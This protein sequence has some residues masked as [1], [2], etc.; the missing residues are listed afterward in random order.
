[1]SMQKILTFGEILIR[2]Q[3]LHDSFFEPGENLLKIYPGGSEA[4]VAVSLAQ[5]G[6]QVEY[7][8]AF[9]ENKLSSEILNV[10]KSYQ[11]DTSKCIYFGDRIGTYLLLSA[12]GLTNGEVIYDRK[13][14]SFSQLRS[15]HIDIDRLFDGVD[16]F[17]WSA[18]SP[19]LNQ[20]TADMMEVL[21]Q[22]AKARNIC[23]SVDLNDRSKLWQYGK[24][25][26]DVMPK[27][28]AYCQ[29]IMGNIW[30][31]N[32]MLGTPIDPTFNRET[33]AA[34][35]IDFANKLATTIFKDYPNALHIAQ[36]FRFMDNPKHN[37]FYGTYHTPTQ[38][39]TSKTYETNEIIDR[40]GSGDAFM[41]GL[42]YAIRSTINPEEIINM[43]TAAGYQKLFIEG[44]F[45]QG[46]FN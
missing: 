29:V 20:E 2:Q 1:M 18:L 12:N 17:H 24:D 45:G 36:T 5:M 13:Y 38:N 16:W 30:A 42:I 4:N 25:P 34:T 8:S 35:Y 10:L 3:S 39:S 41:A 9:P 46:K 7:V 14:A 23:I 28:V 40:I 11:V 44:D 15:K 6:S 19:A 33:P 27:L 37:L 43:A 26:I 31:A 22:A 21:L 32:K